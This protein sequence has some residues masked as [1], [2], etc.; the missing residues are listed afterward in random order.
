MATILV[1]DDVDYFR[2]GVVSIL[3]KAGHTVLEAS[4]GTEISGLIEKNKIDLLIMDVVMPKKGGMET[5]FDL[6]HKLQDTK[7][8]IVTGQI[9]PDSEAFKKFINHFGAQKV[10]FKPFK[11]EELLETVDNLLKK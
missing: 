11:K 2:A 4:D 5:L 1:V 9:S 8:I 7:I 10:L 6:Y 3:K